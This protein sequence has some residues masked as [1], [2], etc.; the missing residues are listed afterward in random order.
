LKNICCQQHFDIRLRLQENKQ[1]Q[2][3]PKLRNT[4]FYFKYTHKLQKVFE[5]DLMM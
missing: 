3:K 5:L 1:K 4:Q 2:N